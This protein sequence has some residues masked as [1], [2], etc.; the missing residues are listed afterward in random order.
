[1][2]EWCSKCR[3]MLPPGSN[4]CPRCRQKIR[5][6]SKIE[7]DITPQDILKLSVYVLGI[8]LI[9]VVLAIGLGAVCTLV[10]R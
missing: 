3:A 5:S 7:T 8:V 4:R 6:S 10:L 1:M 9:P 2:V